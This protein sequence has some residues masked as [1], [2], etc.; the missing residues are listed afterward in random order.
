M[1]GAGREQGC[2]WGGVGGIA[3]Q[4]HHQL[5]AALLV[6]LLDLQLLDRLV[7]QVDHLLDIVLQLKQSGLRCLLTAP[8]GLQRVLGQAVPV[9]LGLRG[10]TPLG[11]ICL[12]K[13][14]GF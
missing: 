13:G 10:T 9:L 2:V 14:R 3:H 4:V 6:G 11:R 7:L 5:E 1:G 12:D 8:A